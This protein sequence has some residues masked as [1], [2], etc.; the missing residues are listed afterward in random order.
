MRNI[1]RETYI[2]LLNT[3]KKIF[4]L[5]KLDYIYF[6]VQRYKHPNVFAEPLLDLTPMDMVKH[7]RYSKTVVKWVVDRVDYTL[8]IDYPLRYDSIVFDVGGYRGTWSSLIKNKYDS[9]IHIFE[10]Q[11]EFCNVL[12]EKFRSD[13]KIFIH[14]YG[15]SDGQKTVMLSNEGMGS[16]VYSKKIGG[17]EIEL[18]DIKQ[19]LDKLRIGQ[20]DLIKINIEGGEYPLLR[21]MIDTGIIK[22]FKNIQVQFHN[23]YPNARRLRQAIR[24]SLSCSHLL[25]WDYPFIM[26]NWERRDSY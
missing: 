20:V 17:V 21:R 9:Y 8:R 4:I 19:V 24:K 25:T 12:E 6:L 7:F 10:P 11:P 13:A 2:F 15:L 16:S 26:E 3:A 22:Y 14:R 5:L 1:I 23:F 18:K